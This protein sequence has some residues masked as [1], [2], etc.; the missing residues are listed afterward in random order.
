[1][2]LRPVAGAY[3]TD[4]KQGPD[5]HARISQETFDAA[6]QENID[7]FAMEPEEAVNDAVSQ[8]ESQGVNLSN[9]VKRA[10]GAAA[11]DDPAAVVA[12]RTLK[13]ALES[14][15]DADD[16]E[17]ET[18][19]MEYA[20]GRMK[21]MFIKIDATGAVALAEAAAALRTACQK[22]KE[23]LALV[24]LN[25]AV[26]TLVSAALAVLNT[27]A[28][29]PPILEALAVVL[30]DSEAREQLG[31]RGIAALTAVIRRH[32]DQAGVV[33]AGFHACRS[34][35]L[36]HENHRQQ[37]VTA[38]KLLKLILP[39][40]KTYADDGPT[41]LAAC[42]ALRATTLSDDARSRTS[43]GLEH[44]R[45]AIELRVAPLL[46]QAA[47]THGTKSVAH[48]AE[49][50]ATLSRLAVTDQICSQLAELDALPLA[51]TELGNHMT[52]AGVAKQAC[53]F[54]ASISG[55]DNCKVS[56]VEGH[57]H[58]AIIQ[59]ML[60]HPNNAGMQTDAVAALGNMCL[61]MPLNCEAI[62][63]AGGLP[64]IATAFQQHVGH[65]RMQSKGPLAI[66]N[67]VGR[68]PELIPQLKELG[69]EPT[70]REVMS[71]HEDGYV[72]NLA[73]AALREL[74]CDVHLKE[75]FQGT[76]EDAHTLTQGDVDGENHWDKFLETPV[77]QEAIRAEMQ[78]EGVLPDSYLDAL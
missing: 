6:V 64:A 62:A 36:V 11:E 78:A 4:E 21:M 14:S 45:A 54:L 42:G 23:Q 69:V 7:E 13:E 26:D 25:G 27:A 33:R 74:H 77:A 43:K 31:Q 55:N 68:N 1:M 15:A 75:Q 58:V 10:P 16:A 71:M 3:H 19:E 9:I 39:A 48:L 65:K 34:A 56:I 61:R 52:D 18:L 47:R 44:A 40:L 2:G 70:L 72:H 76:L 29:L 59:A 24:T 51:I 57:G 20:G 46:L 37:F 5:L 30:L 12:L 50:L 41:F 17:E 63:E 22:E 67:L 8:F 38:A 49:L 60:L 73:K 35:M 32:A 53:F 28:A 66:R